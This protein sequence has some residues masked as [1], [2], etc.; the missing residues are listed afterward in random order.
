MTITEH[1]Q[2]VQRASTHSGRDKPALWLPRSR[3]A[4][5]DTSTAGS[6]PAEV[7]CL[8]LRRR[9]SLL[10]PL[11]RPSRSCVT[12]PALLAAS[13]LPW[14]GHH[15][16]TVYLLLGPHHL[17]ISQPSPCPP[18]PLSHILHYFCNGREAGV[19]FNHLGSEYH[20]TARSVHPATVIQL[21]FQVR[22]VSCHLHPAG[23]ACLR[24]RKRKM[25]CPLPT[26]G[27]PTC[28]WLP[29]T[30]PPALRRR[31]ARMSTVRPRK[32][33]GRLRIR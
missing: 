6:S 9:A 27:P 26:P 10:S 14:T 20:P 33:G 21:L 4:R 12:H 19:H 24:C 11:R 2:A 22:S 16:S 13:S 29:L 3:Q 15:T 30:P 5:F 32:E 18:C 1:G 31:E 17:T 23:K 8:V 25:V 7:V 28:H